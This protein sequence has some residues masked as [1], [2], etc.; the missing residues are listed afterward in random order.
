VRHPIQVEYDATID[1][2]TIEGTKF[3]G[4][5]F[6]AFGKEG[7]RVGTVFTITEHGCAGFTIRRA[8]SL[9]DRIRLAWAALFGRRR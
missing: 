6:R 2:L 8:E 1:T 7:M 4:D 9:L 3:S 5:L